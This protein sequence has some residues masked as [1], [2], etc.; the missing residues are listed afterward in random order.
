MKKLTR[1]AL[2]LL[3]ALAL[4]MIMLAQTTVSGRVTE[5]TNN[6]PVAGASVL[7]TGTSVGTTTD[8]DGRFTVS[9]PSGKT[10]LTI[11]FAGFKSQTLAVGSGPLQVKLAEDFGKLEEVVISGLT[12]TVKR[13][14]LA[15]A[16]ATINSKQLTGTAPAQTFDAALSGKIPGA[17]I[18]ANSGAPGGGISVKLRGVT[19]VFGN[20]QPL[21]VV[22]GVFVDNTATPS[23]T[24][25]VTNAQ[26]AGNST[27]QDN[28]SSRI[29]DIN[30]QDIENVE[31]L[32]GASAA[33]IYGSKAAAGVVIIT[34]KR[35]RAGK[36]RVNFSQDI[37][38]VK[39]QHLLGVRTW[40]LQKV[41]DGHPGDET[42]FNDALAAG[43]I[44]DYE[45]EVFG[46]TG[47][48]TN[49]RI[50]VSGGNDK[51]SLFLSGTV[52][53]E[54][55][56]VK[57]TGY[58]NNTIRLNLDHKIIDRVSVGVSAT[59]ANTSSDRGIT[60]NDNSGVSLGVALSSTPT[61]EDLHQD[62]N[63][64]WPRNGYAASNPLETI[65][66]MTNN[67]TT[68]R[69]I[70]GGNVNAKLLESERSS[71]SLILRGGVDH[72]DLKTLAIFPSS[73]Q[74][75][76]NT[77]HGASI[78][79]NATNTNLN[80]IASLVN[81]FALN[82]NVD[83]TTSLG[84]T[85]EQVSYDLINSVAT[86]LIGT[87]TN[88]DQSGALSATQFRT[89]NRDN[90]YFI[91]EEVRIS[92]YLFV[93]G[94]VRFDKSTNNG[95]PEKYSTFPKGAISWNLSKMS[96]WHSSLIN[97]FKLRVA[98]GEA[99]NFPAYGS[100]FTTLT[101]FNTGGNPGSI[102]NTIQGE[103]T[104][105]QERQTELEAGFDLSMMDGKLNFEASVYQKKIYDFL[106]QAAA[107]PS[108]G[109][110]NKWVNA[111]DLRNQGI[112]LSLTAIPISSNSIRWTSTTNFWM[113]RSK[114]TRLSVPPTPLGAFGST[115]GTFYIEEGKSATQLYGIREGLPPGVIG[116]IEPDFQ[117]TFL[118][119]LTFH[120]NWSLR[121]LFHLKQGGDN[122]NLTQLLSDL[123]LTSYDYD[124]ETLKSGVKNGPYRVSQL[125]T[126]STIFAQDASYFKV[127]EIGLY[128]TFDA[129]N[130]KT[131]RGLR[132]GISANNWFTVSKYKSYDPEV[133]NFGSGFSTGVEVTPFPSSRRAMFSVSIDF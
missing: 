130:W 29:A 72:Y 116:D 8:A 124:Q 129:T 99:G 13:S 67:E 41:T 12:T 68:N 115:L 42:K 33:A 50:S 94:G 97:N 117:M 23:N 77:T 53:K 7:V 98:Y 11:S 37:G 73:L 66:K 47:F 83:L 59:Y 74:F 27:T 60:N 70:V 118:N 57:N 128:Y 126:T 90:G 108:T 78:Q 80:W 110:A 127:R 15:N 75:E 62:A 85:M 81:K 5:A 34:T 119:E 2:P 46:N 6:N 89:Q 107:Q 3:I 102:V 52:K 63:G 10:Q 35:G 32:K 55:G 31:V 91:Q 28:P 71:T 121:F 120:K 30:P 61:Y 95:D 113:N 122:L 112:E 21:F 19:S 36:T 87:Q 106:L 1:K 38:V 40:D 64:N 16:V 48:I 9:V 84:A 56:I 109:F 82:K 133:S 79:G 14:N 123:G 76:E 22:D 25:F 111:G 86:Q 65:A 44:Y 58:K 101:P 39:V 114:V 51:T 92:D 125:G 24:N 88:V 104:I 100:K 93:T 105:K 69:F 103:P 20:T 4:P 45:K 132:L 54:D 131:V 96:F 49:S 26:G 43:K 18:N 17:T